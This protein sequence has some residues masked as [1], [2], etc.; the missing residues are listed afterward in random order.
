MTK[1]LCVQPKES[2]KE[3]LKA[4]VEEKK[5]KLFHG[6][7][8][9]VQTVHC[10]GLMCLYIHLFLFFYTTHFFFFLLYLSELH[11][12]LWF[13]FLKTCNSLT[14]VEFCHA[15]GGD[16]G[17]G[18]C[19]F[20]PEVWSP[21]VTNQVLDSPHTYPAGFTGKMSPLLLRLAGLLL[22][23]VWQA[24][25]QALGEGRKDSRL[26]HGADT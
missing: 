14:Q 4:E 13:H 19:D 16:G 23:M 2:R 21:I 26:S 9:T 3:D 11:I 18:Q 5:T 10:T 1:E 8:H 22:I 25:A 24:A 20:Y 12:F 15:G 17:R 7:P 6:I